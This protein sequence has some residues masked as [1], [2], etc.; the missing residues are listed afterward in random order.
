MLLKPL[1]DGQSVMIKHNQGVVPGTVIKKHQTPRSYIVETQ[2]GRQLRRNRIH[3]QPTKASF[4]PS[5]QEIS[6]KEQEIRNPQNKSENVNISE[7]RECE[8]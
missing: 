1:N 3:V 4:Q 8:I 7:N 2:D 6:Y 5:N